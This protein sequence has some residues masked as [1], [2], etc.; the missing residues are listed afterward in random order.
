MKKI[1]L[2]PVLVLGMFMFVF[3]AQAAIITLDLGTKFSGDTPD[4]TDNPPWLRATFDDENTP[5]SVTLTM[6]A[7]S[8]AAGQFVNSNKGWYFNFEPGLNLTDNDFEYLSD[9]EATS[10][11]VDEDGFESDGDGYFDINIEFDISNFTAGSSSTYEITLD[12]ITAYSF[13][14]LSF[15]DGGQGEYYTAAHVKNTPG[16]EG[17][18]WIGAGTYTVVPIPSAVWLL[19]NGLIALAGIRNRNKFKK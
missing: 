14:Y 12:G 10:I 1:L 17:S 13:A 8:L 19:G 11:S 9:V 3:P 6:E 7:L 15:P 5:G 18:G 2:L 4:P 16:D